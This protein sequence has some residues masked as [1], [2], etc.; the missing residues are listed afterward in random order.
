MAFRDP[1][2]LVVDTDCCTCYGGWRLVSHLV[3]PSVRAALCTPVSS[4][5]RVVVW[6]FYGF[7]LSQWVCLCS[8]VLVA[9]RSAAG[10]YNQ[11]V[12]GRVSWLHCQ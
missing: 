2:L 7:L 9:S 8:S 11:D 12:P 6:S 5:V 1:L 4:V 10:L 3:F